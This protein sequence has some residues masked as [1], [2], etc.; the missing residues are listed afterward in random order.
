MVEG[1]SVHP[2]FGTIQQNPVARLPRVGFNIKG[3]MRNVMASS[4]SGWL[5]GAALLQAGRRRATLNGKK[6]AEDRAALRPVQP[7]G[8]VA[9]VEAARL[10][11][12]SRN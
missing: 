11:C 2:S 12:S 4:R 7:G 6:T 3:Y 10:G 1:S 8:V 9:A 5:I